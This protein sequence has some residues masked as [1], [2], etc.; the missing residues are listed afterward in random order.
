MLGS[1]VLVEVVTTNSNTSNRTVLTYFAICAPGCSQKKLG[2]V[3]D[4]LTHKAACN[5][6]VIKV[7]LLTTQDTTW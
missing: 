2:S 7:R 4:E 6:I 1:G 3:S 5:T